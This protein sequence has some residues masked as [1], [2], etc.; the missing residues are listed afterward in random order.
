MSGVESGG[1]MMSWKMKI[2]C[3]D[4]VSP[5]QQPSVMDT[6]PSSSPHHPPPSPLLPSPTTPCTTCQCALTVKKAGG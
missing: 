3:V 6:G 5:S 1:H 4:K 2:D